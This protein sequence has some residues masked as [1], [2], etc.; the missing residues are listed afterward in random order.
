MLQKINETVS[1]LKE[2]ANFIPEV[3][4]VLGSGLGGLADKIDVHYAIEYKDIP[5]FAQSTVEGHKGRLIFG[6]LGGK[7][8]AAMQGR[9]HFYEGY[10]MEDVT[11]PVRVLKFLGAKYY[12]VSN[13]SGGLNPDIYTG[14][15]M[16]ISDH[17]SLFRNPL[18]G[19]H[20]DEFGARFP[21]MS[22]TYSKVLIEKAI[23]IAQKHNIKV[24]TGVYIGSSG[25]TLET[26]AEYRFFRI[27]GGDATGMSTV[28]EVIVAHQMGMICFGISVITNGTKPATPDGETTHSEVQNVAGKAEP[29]MT[30]IFKEL[31][32]SL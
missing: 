3:A 9:F 21:D 15:L 14:E 29:Y 30:L 24:H 32:E 31:I 26:S 18:I 5:N 20:Y 28:P 1:F 10:P 6:Y 2:K 27:I 13:A 8:V 12:F 16:I 4:I 7:K 11:F 25:P 23:A 19:K 22:K 17:I